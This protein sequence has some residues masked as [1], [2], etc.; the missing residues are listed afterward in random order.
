M[1]MRLERPLG[2]FVLA[3]FFIKIVIFALDPVPKFF[4]GDSGWYLETAAHNLIPQDRSFTYGFFIKATTWISST[5]WP[6][7]ACQ[8]LASVISCAIFAHIL[9]K[10]LALRPSVAYPL[11]ISC[12]L[13]P[14]QVLY[15][16]YVMAETLSLTFLALYVLAILRYLKGRS[17]SILFLAHLLGT[18][19][20]SLRINFLPLTWVNSFLAPILAFFGPGAKKDSSSDAGLIHRFS[21]ARA[22]EGI[23]GCS[24]HL[25]LSLG[26]MLAMHE[27]YKRCFSLLSG[28][29]PGYNAAGGY[30]L[31]AAWAPVVQPEDFPH[32]EL[33]SKIFHQLP[34]DLKDRNKRAN[35]LWEYGALID[36]IRTHLPGPEGNRSAQAT[37][38][39]AFKR[40][41]L[42]V[43]RL[44]VQ[45]FGD[46]F[47]AELLKEKIRE[48]L[49]VDQVTFYKDFLDTHGERYSIPRAERQPWTLTRRYY[50]KALIWYWF[51]L[52]SPALGAMGLIFVRG[53]AASTALVLLVSLSSCI[54]AVAALSVDP[55]VRY[56]H[57]VGWLALCLLGPVIEGLWALRSQKRR[58]NTRLEPSP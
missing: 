37:A 19:L 18:A 8:M 14:I 11:G 55:I 6:L 31:L 40:D 17:L 56:L 24:I 42:G 36:R 53:H 58:G 22:R 12:A 9:S 47:R 57:P 43:V 38:L 27:G 25:F 33:R 51:L 34:Y 52:L 2:S 7:M 5:L 46:Y 32:E 15:E 50:E 28:S 45:S 49:A 16:R 13:E 23:L 44:W 1:G 39:N 21:N 35:Q 20:I 54:L 29:P 41:P 30:F 26:L 4:F 48:D 3:I 10:H